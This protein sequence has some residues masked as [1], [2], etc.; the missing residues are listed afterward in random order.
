MLNPLKIFN[1]VF[2]HFTVN[3]DRINDALLKLEQ[4][5]VVVF[6]LSR[7]NLSLDWNFRSLLDRQITTICSEASSS[8]IKFNTPHGQNDQ[9]QV[10][11]IESEELSKRLTMTSFTPSDCIIMSFV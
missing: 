11:E 1:S 6:D 2:H 9:W 7:H 10:Q 4:E 3:V 5:L 8:L